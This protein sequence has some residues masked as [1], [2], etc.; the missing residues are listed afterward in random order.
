MV[1]EKKIQYG[2][3]IMFLLSG[4]VLSYCSYFANGDIGNGVLWYLGQTVAFCGAV[5]GLS[6]YARQ[7]KAE[8]KNYIDSRFENSMEN[9]NE[10]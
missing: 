7:S 1:T 4:V 6:L 3:S 10:Q 8:L 2:T 5:F 9:G